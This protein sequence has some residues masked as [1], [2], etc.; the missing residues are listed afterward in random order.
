MGGVRDEGQVQGS[1]NEV[2]EGVSLLQ[3]ARCEPTGLGGE[4]FECGRGGQTPD[5]THRDAEQCP[6][7]EELMER[8]DKAGSELNDRTKEEICY[9]RP[10]PSKAIG[11]DTE[12]DLQRQRSSALI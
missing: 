9:K 3:D 6:H 2:S 10:L 5:T 1:R 4:I 12:D 7:R 8:L 11:E